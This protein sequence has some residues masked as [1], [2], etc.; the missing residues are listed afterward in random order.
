[1]YVLPTIK[2]Y[3]RVTKALDQACQTQITVRAAQWVLKLEKLTAGRSLE[4]NISLSVNFK[5]I[6]ANFILKWTN[7]G[8]I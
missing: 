6:L 3:L 8:H 2:R 7:I 5:H 4:K 1:M